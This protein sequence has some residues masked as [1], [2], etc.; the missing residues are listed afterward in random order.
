VAVSLPWEAP[1]VV[2]TAL[3]QTGTVAAAATAQARLAT[4]VEEETAL[5]WEAV[6]S[7][8]AW[9]EEARMVAVARVASKGEA[10]MAAV[11]LAAERAAAE[12]EMVGREAVGRKAPSHLRRAGCAHLVR[13]TSVGCVPCIG[14]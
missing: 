1:V 8:R 10:G 11:G 13:R 14:R 3:G 7:R 5:G 6:D 9:T 2:A 12:E 4:V